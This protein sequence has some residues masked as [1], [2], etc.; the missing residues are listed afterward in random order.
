MKPRQTIYNGIPMRS[1]LEARVAAWLDSMGL[2]WTYEPH[3]FA[4]RD[5]QYLP[6]FEIDTS[7]AGHLGRR[8][9]LEVKGKLSLDEYFALQ[10]RIAAIVSASEPRAFVALADE[11]MLMHGLV[12][13]Y[14]L[15]RLGEW[16]E[17][18]FLELLINSRTIEVPQP[19]RLPAWNARP[20]KEPDA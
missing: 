17:V 2:V 10:E 5:G 11:K 15:P 3:A 19:W 4:S 7:N 13:V 6:D 8:L 12:G 14:N 18:Y 20:E 9:F 1:R 16:G